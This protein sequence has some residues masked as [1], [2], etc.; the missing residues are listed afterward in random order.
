MI[1]ACVERNGGFI[2]IE[3]PPNLPQAMLGAR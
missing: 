3:L 2:R 1:T